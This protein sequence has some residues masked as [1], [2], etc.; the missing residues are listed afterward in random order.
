MS[1]R[2]SY[3]RAPEDHHFE[4]EL[5]PLQGADDHANLDDLKDVKLE[6]NADLGEC[7]VLVREVL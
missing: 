7:R 3:R 6:L 5:R 1:E 2:D 4:E